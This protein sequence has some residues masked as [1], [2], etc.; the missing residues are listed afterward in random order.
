MEVIPDVAHASPARVLAGASARADLVVLGRNSAG[1]S[2]QP[3]TGA[4]VHALLSHAH[5]PVAIIPE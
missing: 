1:D 3:S 4:T 2:R 5:G